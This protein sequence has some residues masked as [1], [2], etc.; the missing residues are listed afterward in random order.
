MK[1]LAR[2]EKEP[3]FGVIQ[4]PRVAT[5]DVVIALEEAVWYKLLFVMVQADEPRSILI[6][7]EATVALK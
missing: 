6:P 3:V 1:P 4:I 2:S 5:D 7:V